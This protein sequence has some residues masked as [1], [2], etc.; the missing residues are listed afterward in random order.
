M[1]GGYSVDLH[2]THC[3]ACQLANVSG[4]TPSAHVVRSVP[5]SSRQHL[6]GARTLPAAPRHAS[7]LMALPV[8][9]QPP[10][11]P[12]SVP[13]FLLIDIHGQAPQLAALQ[14]IHG[15]VH[16]HQAPSADV[17]DDGA[18]AHGLDAAQQL[19]SMRGLSIWCYLEAVAASG[20]SPASTHLL[21]LV[22]LAH[23]CIQCCLLI[24]MRSGHCERVCIRPYSAAGV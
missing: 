18:R 20:L 22:V 4:T 23:G 16:I 21:M 14:G 24:T 15:C 3:K 9:G 7:R 1:T 5:S 13:T 2:A 10:R 8:H 19:P 17:H 12:V 6:A 11:Y